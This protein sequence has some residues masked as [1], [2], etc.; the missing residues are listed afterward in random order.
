MIPPRPEVAS[1]GEAEHGGMPAAANASPHQ[2]M[3]DFSA[4][5]NPFGP[6]PGVEEAIRGTCI[7]NY[8][9]REARQLREALSTHLS[10]PAACLLA[11]N[12]SSEMLYLLA[13]AYLRPLDKCLIL[14]PT[15]SEYARVSRLMGAEVTELP[16]MNQVNSG[17]ASTMIGLTLQRLRPRMLFVCHPNNPTGQA[18]PTADFARWFHEFP[19]TL[20]IIDEAYI[21]FSRGLASLIDVTLDNVIVIR[22]LTKAYGLAG[23][24]LGYAAAHPDTIEALCR[25]R[26]PWSVSAFAQ[27]AGVA[28]L[29]QRAWVEHRIDDLRAERDR[30]VIALKLL[31]YEVFQTET[32]FFL[33]RRANVPT[34]IRRLTYQGFIVRDAASFGLPSVIRISPQKSDANTA[35][36]EALSRATG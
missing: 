25:V 10:I 27:A 30:M 14:G 18:A 26:P 17:S 32:H 33:A 23:I 24:R 1:L 20:F 21:E 13:L 28:A 22:S 19:E 9:D 4:S 12:G 34:V 15:Y 2:R 3:L 8:P 36:C 11:S 6:P 31:H 35:L 7:A 5:I 16:V 29:A